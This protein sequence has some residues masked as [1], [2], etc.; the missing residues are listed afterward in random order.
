VEFDCPYLGAKVELTAERERHIARTHPEVL[1]PGGSIGETLGE[2]DAVGSRSDGTL[3]FIRWW[4][5][6]VGGH[7]L[8]VCVLGNRPGGTSATMR[9]WVVT[10]WMARR[11]GPWKVEWERN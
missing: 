1:S 10:A 8:V 7:W 6:L 9:W 2:P 4:P 3:A 5:G 11:R